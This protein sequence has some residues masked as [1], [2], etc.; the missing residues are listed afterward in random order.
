MTITFPILVN[1][2]F[3]AI[4]ALVVCVNGMKCNAPPTSFNGLLMVRYAVTL[5]TLL[6]YYFKNIMKKQCLGVTNLKL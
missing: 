4:A 5:H 1:C 3:S 6:D 2:G